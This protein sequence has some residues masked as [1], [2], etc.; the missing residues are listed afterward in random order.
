MQNK[1]AVSRLESGNPLAIRKFPISLLICLTFFSAI[2]AAQPDDS[3]K[4]EEGIESTRALRALMQ[5]DPHRPIYHFVAPEGH[6][7]P[8]D[9]NG[10]I[11]WKG[12]YH[13]GFI[14]SGQTR[15]SPEVQVMY[16]AMQ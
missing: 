13:F 5:S 8:F 14:R 7:N 4:I 11:Y 9:P 16:G 3:K 1:T 6:T 15:T 12:K 10:G 2:Y